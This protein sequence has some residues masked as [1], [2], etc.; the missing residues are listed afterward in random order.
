MTDIR[1]DAFWIGSNV[2]IASQISFKVSSDYQQNAVCLQQVIA[3]IIAAEFNDHVKVCLGA[4]NG[5][6]LTPVLETV[7]TWKHSLHENEVCEPVISEAQQNMLT[8]WTFLLKQTT[9]QA[10]PASARVFVTLHGAV[11]LAVARL[12]CTHDCWT[13]Y[14][15]DANKDRKAAHAVLNHYNG[16]SEK[17]RKNLKVAVAA[18]TAN[19]I[20]ARSLRVPEELR[21]NKQFIL[22]LLANWTRGAALE[23]ADLKLKSDKALVVACTRANPCNFKHA[24]QHL[25]DDKEVFFAAF[26][27]EPRQIQYAGPS[28]VGDK[29]TMLACINK[30]PD[31]FKCA[32]KPLKGDMDVAIA[33]VSKDGG[34]LS[35][36]SF[37][38]R[39]NKT[40][41][42]AA[43]ANK[44][45]ALKHASEVLRGNKDVVLAAVLNDGEA[46]LYMDPALQDDEQ[47]TR[48]ASAYLRT[49]SAQFIAQCRQQYFTKAT[50]TLISH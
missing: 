21:S 7:Q 23:F 36:A 46:I 29:A 8:A 27:R 43:V 22:S 24:A 50:G 9:V 14:S 41:V 4:P 10:K 2:R 3:G 6:E 15:C 26:D 45:C 1:I 39:D 47:I 49:H 38:L 19:Q 32:S 34:L 16:M 44:G 33:A 13:L 12:L 31:S 48:A 28:V 40:V 11:D 18:V 42:L 5:P 30:W 25:R 37:E 20:Y 35:E 17:L